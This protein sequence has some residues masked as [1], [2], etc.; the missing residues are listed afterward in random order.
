M[1]IPVLIIPL[2]SWYDNYY[3]DSVTDRKMWTEELNMIHVSYMKFL[4]NVYWYVLFIYLLN[5]HILMLPFIGINYLY[6]QYSALK[7]T[8]VFLVFFYF[9]FSKIIFLTSLADLLSICPRIQ[10][11]KQLPTIW[12]LSGA[13]TYGNIWTVNYFQKTCFIN[14]IRKFF[15]RETGKTF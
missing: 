4:F 15:I 1:V 7:K 6:Y 3:S 13:L 2:W 12:F 8:Q 9:Y 11:Y 5:H 14:I 10:T